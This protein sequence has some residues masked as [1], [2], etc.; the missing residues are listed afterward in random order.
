MMNTRLKGKGALITG[1]H[2]PLCCA[3]GPSHGFGAVV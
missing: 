1:A 3:W 2:N